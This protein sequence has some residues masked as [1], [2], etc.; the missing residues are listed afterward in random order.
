MHI[1][2]EYAN[3][4]SNPNVIKE[5]LKSGLSGIGAEIVMLRLA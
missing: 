1:A 2:C 5:Y 3:V 4:S